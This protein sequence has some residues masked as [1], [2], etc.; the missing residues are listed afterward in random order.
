MTPGERVKQVRKS[1][2][3]SQQRLA[4]SIKVSRSYINDIEGGRAEPSFNFLRALSDVYNV[5]I[6][7][8]AIGNGSMFRQQ[9]AQSSDQKALT[10]PPAPPMPPSDLAMYQMYLKLPKEEQERIKGVIQER[11]QIAE[12]RERLDKLEQERQ[13]RCA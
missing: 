9:N 12:M 8:V 11:E 3:I 10:I 1:L 2:S 6:D 7:W 13:E 5:S 4:E